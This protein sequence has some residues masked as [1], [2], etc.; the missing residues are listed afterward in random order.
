MWHF[1]VNLR[2]DPR[3]VSV[4]IVNLRQDPQHVY[5]GISGDHLAGNLLKR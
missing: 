1:L 5:V 2:Q 4:G 3:H